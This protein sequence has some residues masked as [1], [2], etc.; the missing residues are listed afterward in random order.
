MQHHNGAMHPEHPEHPQPHVAAGIQ[1]NA[2]GTPA[3]MPQ[4]TQQMTQQM[5]QQMSH[6]MMGDSAGSGWGAMQSEQHVVGAWQNPQQGC[7]G[8][9]LIRTADLLFAKQAH[10][11][12]R[13]RGRGSLWLRRMLWHCC[14]TAVT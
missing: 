1:M 7:A 4:M 3:Q 11:P 14:G 9:E 6:Q 12:T 13:R 8:R 5:N 2:D 10:L